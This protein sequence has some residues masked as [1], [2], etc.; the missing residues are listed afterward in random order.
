[1]SGKIATRKSFGMALADFGEKY[2]D[3]VCFDAD[4]SKSTMS[5]LFAKKYPGRFFE[6]GIQEANMIGC[7]AGMSFMGKIPFICSF[8]A[9][10]TGRFDQIR[11]SIG[12][13][14]ANVKLI[15]THCGVAIG[16]DGHSQM[17]LEDI[18]LM[19]SIPNMV[20]LQ[21][22][23]DKECR[24]M[25]EWAINHQGPVYLRLT[26]QELPQFNMDKFIP[27]IFPQLKMGEKMAFLATGGMLEAALNAAEGLAKKGTGKNPAVFNANL[28]KPLA[29]NF[30]M[31]LADKY[32][33]L[34]VFED[35]TVMGGTG[36][37]I[38]EWVSQNAKIPRRV[39]RYGVNDSFGESG[40]PEALLDK[41][42]LTATKIE[43]YFS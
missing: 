32:E 10:L 23:D 26:R 40:T 38:A 24:E 39:I 34:V 18:A 33:T 16:E 8:G 14:N 20:V 19:R 3:V 28:A 5:I 27:G 35:H 21:P 37:A 22:A 25:V 4:L 11:M 36:S 12:Y 9:F 13:A 1:M 43:N 15:G 17:G 2:K 7:A 30:M 29:D 6:M 31:N 42:G 41:H